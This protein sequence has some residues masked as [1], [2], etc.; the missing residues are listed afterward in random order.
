M[1]ILLSAC[2]LS[3]DLVP[4]D[5]PT[6][7]PDLPALDDA[8]VDEMYRWDIVGLSACVVKDHRIA[9]C[10]SYGVADADAARPVTLHTPFM[11]ASISK[12]FVAMAAHRA[13][14]EGALD[15][16]DRVADWLPYPLPA[17]AGDMRVWHLLTHTSGIDDDWGVLDEDVVHDRDATIDLDTYLQSYLS[18]DGSRYHERHVRQHEPGDHWRYSNVGYALLADVVQR[19]TGEPF[20]AYTASRIFEPL[21]MASAAWFLA[22]VS[23]PDALAR[24]HEVVRGD[25][26]PLPHLGFPTWPD[27]QLRMHVEDLA[28]FVVALTDGGSGI[29]PPERVVEMERS[30]VPHLGHG[31]WPVDHQGLGLLGFTVG[32]RA[33]VGH[34]GTSTGIKSMMV[35]DPERAIGAVMLTNARGAGGLHPLKS[36]RAIVDHLLDATAL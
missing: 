15:L 8:L 17:Q 24:P 32:D 21:G 30:Q 26:R 11:I 29:V 31:V 18:P 19:A 16:E 10:R 23:D 13:V 14:E 2:T 27:G 35:Y 4:H 7:Y 36:S 20:A 12:V 5:E 22:D 6:N 34:G 3:L 25:A 1:L 9:W 28:R 33:L